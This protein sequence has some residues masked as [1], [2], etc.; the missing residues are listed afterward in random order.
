MR[1][2][3][4]MASDCVLS[5]HSTCQIQLALHKLSDTHHRLPFPKIGYPQ[6]AVRPDPRGIALPRTSPA[7][8]PHFT[9]AHRPQG[10]AAL[11]SIALSINWFV[12][13]FVGLLFLPLGRWLADE[14]PYKEGCV[15]YHFASMLFVSVVMF[16]RAY[17]P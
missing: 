13:V 6:G 11:S 2:H 5:P 12:N 4:F 8:L 16:L 3:I 10:V 1:A 17:R 14:N 15:F 7:P 9:H